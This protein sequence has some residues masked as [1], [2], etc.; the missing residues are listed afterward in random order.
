MTPLAMRMEPKA[1]FQVSLSPSRSTANKTT[2]TTLNLSMGATREAGARMPN[3][4]QR[5]ANQ[6]SCRGLCTYIVQGGNNDGA[7]PELA[8]NR[9]RNTSMLRT[10]RASERVSFRIE[11]R[12]CRLCL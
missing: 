11:K 3:R 9:V 7:R 5:L 1:T 8:A 6:D 2:R 12:C 10:R 4:V